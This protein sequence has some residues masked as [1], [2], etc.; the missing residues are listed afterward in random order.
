MRRVAIISHPLRANECG[1][2]LGLEEN[3]DLSILVCSVSSILKSISLPQDCEVILYQKKTSILLFRRNILSVM[4][5]WTKNLLRG[6]SLLGLRLEGL[7]QK[8]RV[9]I[10]PFQGWSRIRKRGLKESSSVP[11]NRQLLQTLNSLHK[12]ESISAIVVF[13]VFD[14][15]TILDFAR[16]KEIEVSLR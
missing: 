2:F 6:G 10:V 1:I 16:S 15:P 12:I 11:L 9:R 8:M 5:N 13:D 3:K 7:L 4:R 14:L